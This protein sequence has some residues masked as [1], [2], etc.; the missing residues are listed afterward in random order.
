MLIFKFVSGGREIFY[1]GE[2]PQMTK[3]VFYR[4]TEI[5]TVLLCDLSKFVLVLNSQRK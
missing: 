1:K 5:V 3:L 4:L 2:E